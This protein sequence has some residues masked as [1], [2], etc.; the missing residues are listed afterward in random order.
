MFSLGITVAGAVIKAQIIVL[1]LGKVSSA[2][3]STSVALS[4][5]LG[6]LVGLGISGW[7]NRLYKLAENSTRK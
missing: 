7:T 1:N 5:G 4:I 3:I 6:G 2:D